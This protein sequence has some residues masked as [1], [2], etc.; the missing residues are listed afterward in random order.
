[1][2]HFKY[3]SKK[4]RVHQTGINNVKNGTSNVRIIQ[5]KTFSAKNS[6]KRYYF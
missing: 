1:M 6:N 3:N 5:N 2:Y 4:H